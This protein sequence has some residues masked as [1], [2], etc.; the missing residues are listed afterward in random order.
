MFARLYQRFRDDE[1]LRPR[2][3]GGRP[4][5][6][7][8][9]IDYYTELKGKGVVHTPDLEPCSGRTIGHLT[10]VDKFECPLNGLLHTFSPVDLFSQTCCD[11]W[12]R[13]MRFWK[14]KRKIKFWM[15]KSRGRR[16]SKSKSNRRIREEDSGMVREEEWS[17]GRHPMRDVATGL[18][19]AGVGSS[20]HAVMIASLQSVYTPLPPFPSS[21]RRSSDTD[22][23]MSELLPR[24]V[25][26]NC[27]FRAKKVYHDRLL[28]VEFLEKRLCK[29][30]DS[31]TM[32]PAFVYP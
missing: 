17:F 2:R 27:Y 24:L 16:F 7:P 15:G 20:I 31:Q 22:H 5:R 8:F 3:I 12:R 25:R 30:R 6:H 32:E 19:G 11:R 10:S 18:T 28:P 4:R 14:I 26:V 1:S 21:S 29:D 9:S 13:V 23:S